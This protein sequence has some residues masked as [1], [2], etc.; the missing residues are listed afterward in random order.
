MAPPPTRSALSLC[1]VLGLFGC[2]EGPAGPAGP[3]GAEGLDG[4]DGNPGTQTITGSVEM[5]QGPT[6]R[7]MLRA[8]QRS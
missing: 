2:S 7:A 3:D 4:N 6:L 5:T 1:L 8:P